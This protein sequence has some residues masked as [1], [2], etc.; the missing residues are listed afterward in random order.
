[1]YEGNKDVPERPVQAERLAGV[2][3]VMTTP[4]CGR[5]IN[6]MAVEGQVEGSVA[7][8][9]G[10]AFTEEVITKDGLMVNPSSLD[11]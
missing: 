6:P 7:M 1:M 4:D 11:F 10:C 2:K 8:G 3:G 5:E 9:P